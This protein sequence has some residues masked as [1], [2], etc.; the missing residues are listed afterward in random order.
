MII[1]QKWSLIV[2]SKEYASSLLRLSSWRFV[3]SI[4]LLVAVTNFLWVFLAEAPGLE[5]LLILFLIKF[6]FFQI[7]HF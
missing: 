2:S 7:T 3:N 4:Q 1:S 5:Q 6:Q